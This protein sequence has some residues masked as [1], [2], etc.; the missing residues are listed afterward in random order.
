M[1]RADSLEKTLM[2]GKI[3]GRRRRGWQKMRWLDGISDSMDTSK[4]WE[5]AMDRETWHAVVHGVAKSRTRLSDWAELNWGSSVHGLFQAR[6]LEWIAISFSRVFSQRSNSCLLHWQVRSL[7]LSHHR[8]FIYIFFG[9]ELSQVCLESLG[10]VVLDLKQDFH[11]N[12][13][14]YIF[15]LLSV[16]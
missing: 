4:L 3:E 7:L 11:F 15:R 6:I 14:L 5:L 9:G 10:S 8:S 2:L 16:V 13:L 1:W 12:V